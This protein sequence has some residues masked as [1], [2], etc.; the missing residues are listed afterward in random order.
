MA[1]LARLSGFDRSIY[2][3][4]SLLVEFAICNRRISRVT[5]SP[6]DLGGSLGAG[7]Q[8]AVLSVIGQGVG[9]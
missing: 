2:S 8:P 5:K 4:Q 6:L 1:I 7:W 3:L 9:R